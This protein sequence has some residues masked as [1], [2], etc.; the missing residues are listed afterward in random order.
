VTLMPPEQNAFQIRT[1]R[2]LTSLVGL[3]LSDMW[4]AG[5]QIFEFGVQRPHLNHRGEEVTRADYALHVSC[6][7]RVLSPAGLALGSGDYE[8]PGRGP[9]HHRARAFFEQMDAGLLTVEG[10]EVDASG[11]PRL[12]LG[13]GYLLEIVPMTSVG[14]REHWR[15]LPAGKQPHVVVAGRGSYRV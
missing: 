4:R 8:S 12:Q 6:P 10:V 11:G 13:K 3:P 5:F 9:R 7:W 14:A 1:A 2:A 15:L